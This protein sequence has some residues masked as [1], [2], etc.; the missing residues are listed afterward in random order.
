MPP[1][2][3]TAST[4]WPAQEHITLARGEYSLGID[5]KTQ[6]ARYQILLPVRGSYPQL[7]R[8]MHALLGQLP[9]VVVE[10]VDF[11]RKKHRRHRPHRADPH[12]PLPVEVMMNTKSRSRVGGVLRRGRGA[13]LV[14]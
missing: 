13:D 12:D 6:L 3:S 14:A 5:P 10:D 7:R 8:F 1:S 4:P 11:Q 9:A 2:P